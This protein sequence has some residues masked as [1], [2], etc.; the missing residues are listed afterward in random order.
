MPYFCSFP[1]HRL[2][3]PK[4]WCRSIDD[5]SNALAES[6]WVDKDLVDA[7]DGVP[8]VA[9]FYR[10]VQWHNH[11][12]TATLVDLAVPSMVLHYEDYSANFAGV[13]RNLMDFL[14]LKPIPAVGA[15]D[16]P[17]FI[18][19][20]VYGHYYYSAEQTRAIAAFVKEF[21]MK[22]TWQNLARYFDE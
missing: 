22:M 2:H 17:V 12:F 3:D 6:R 5:D 4:K 21:S 10:Y 11:A 8:C 13:T 7:F 9:E 15:A 16:L 20:K 14:D 19:D 1:I 18:S